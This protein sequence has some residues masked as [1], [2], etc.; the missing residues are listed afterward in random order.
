M[1]GSTTAPFIKLHDGKAAPAPSANWGQ[2]GALFSATFSIGT[3]ANDTAN[4]ITVGIQLTDYF[5]QSLAVP[6]SCMA[7]IADDAV[8]VTAGTAH[9]TSPVIEG[10]IGVM[11]I[12]TTDV[13]W[14]LNSTAAGLLSIDFEDDGTQTVYLVLVA[15]DGRLIV[16]D[17][18]T[19]A[20]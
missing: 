5:G 14:Q 17:A 18:I 10:A 4:V 15:P 13:C 2:E 20:A 6:A 3:E 8:G 7:Y 19:H 16:S 11:R 9:S 12:L 1:T